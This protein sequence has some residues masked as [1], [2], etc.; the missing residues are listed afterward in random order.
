MGAK[1]LQ[2]SIPLLETFIGLWK[3]FYDILTSVS[4][5]K[6]TS[7]ELEQNFLSLKT[8]I[9][10]Q[11]ARLSE[12]LGFESHFTEEVMGILSQIISL[13]D[14]LTL[15]PTQVKRIDAQWHHL[16]ILM[17]GQLGKY[18]A[19]REKEE[20]GHGIRRFFKNPVVIIVFVITVLLIVYYVGEKF[21]H[22]P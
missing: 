18:E 1:H 2:Q 12:V 5:N 13:K 11:Q 19:A 10:H 6:K 4:Q 8:D 21:K 14:Y 17:H 3:S 22:S 7:D 20:T 15:T 16:F 9:A